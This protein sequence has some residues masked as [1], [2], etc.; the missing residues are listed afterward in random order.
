MTHDPPFVKHSTKNIPLINS[1]E[2]PTIEAIEFM[3]IIEDYQNI[4]DYN[5]KQNKN[6]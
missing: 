1:I 5:Q 6:N 4:I 2:H 3:R